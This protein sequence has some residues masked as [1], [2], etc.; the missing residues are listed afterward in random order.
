[1]GIPDISREPQL[2]LA[3]RSRGKEPYKVIANIRKLIEYAFD[4]NQGIY[5]QDELA[6]GANLS[7]EDVS[8]CLS[9]MTE[10]VA[11][12]LYFKRSRTSFY[13]DGRNAIF[14]P[15]TLLRKKGR[16]GLPVASAAY[17]AKLRRV[18]DTDLG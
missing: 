3:I 2:R 6:T 1:M 17:H 5:T 15:V 9:T 11:L 4:S 12:G 10:S 7:L 13:T 14:S 16:S 8:D 18:L